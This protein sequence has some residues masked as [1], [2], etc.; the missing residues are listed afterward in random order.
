MRLFA[1]LGRFFVLSAALSAKQEELTAMVKVLSQFISSPTLQTEIHQ[2]LLGAE[3][4]L[5][6]SFVE[7]ERFETMR[8]QG[9]KL[10]MQHLLFEAKQRTLL[11]RTQFRANLKSSKKGVAE[12]DMFVNYGC[13][14]STA[15]QMSQV[16][17]VDE[18]DAVCRDLAQAY[19]CIKQDHDECDSTTAYNWKLGENGKPTCADA[20]GTCEGDVCRLD[21]EFTSQLVLL[22]TSWN[23]SFHVLNGFDKS[24]ACQ[25]HEPESFKKSSK[26]GTAK[27]LNRS[28]KQ[29]CCGIGLKR[30]LFKTDRFDCCPDGSTKPV[31]T[32]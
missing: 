13:F 6:S 18:I 31:G 12:E 10:Q 7:K 3:E 22:E 23:A 17:P 24:S 32:C 11:A 8:R 2:W 20:V 16:E 4:A 9:K 28:L 19:I 1:V 29:D 25:S 15:P 5:Q 21:L 27:Q 30:H 14:C 26:S